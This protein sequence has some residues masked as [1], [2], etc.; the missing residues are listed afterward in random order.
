M[1]VPTTVDV[2]PSS[3]SSTVDRPKSATF[4]QGSAAGRRGEGWGTPKDTIGGGLGVR[5]GERAEELRGPAGLQSTPP[6]TAKPPPPV[7]F[8]SGWHPGGTR[9]YEPV[10]ARL[11]G[12]VHITRLGAP[13]C[14]HNLQARA[15]GVFLGGTVCKRTFIDYFRSLSLFPAL[16]AGLCT[17]RPSHSAPSH[18]A[19]PGMYADFSGHV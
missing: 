16:Y 8:F 19:R 11:A 3:A 10:H 2:S 14:T 12:T 15:L 13:A 1:G 18:P 6:P 17:Q 9:M 4:E 5:V 7:F